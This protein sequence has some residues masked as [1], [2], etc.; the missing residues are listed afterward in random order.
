MF[1]FENNPFNPLTVWNM[2]NNPFDK[3]TKMLFPRY[4]RRLLDGAGLRAQSPKFYVFFPKQLKG[5]RWSEPY[6]RWLPLG[7]QYYV[8]GSVPA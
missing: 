7:A 3:G 8:W 1:I 4:L 6:I 5:L 2:H